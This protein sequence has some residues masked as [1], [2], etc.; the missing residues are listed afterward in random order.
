MSSSWRRDKHFDGVLVQNVCNCRWRCR[1]FEGVMNILMKSSFKTFYASVKMFMPSLAVL[2]FTQV[3]FCNWLSITQE[4]H[5]IETRICKSTKFKDKNFCNTFKE[6]LEPIY[7]NLGADRDS[8]QRCTG[9]VE[10]KALLHL[11]RNW[12]AVLISGVWPRGTWPGL[13]LMTEQKHSGDVRVM[14]ENVQFKRQKRKGRWKMQTVIIWE[15]WVR[16]SD[17]TQESLAWICAIQTS[18][19]REKKPVLSGSW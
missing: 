18:S 5:L 6:E 14:H 19:W 2:M 16:S 10:P 4:G 13:T 3:F 7:S 8:N 11:G 1:N 9:W 12:N 17:T 15:V